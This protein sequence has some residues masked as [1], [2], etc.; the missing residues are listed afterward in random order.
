MV[1]DGRE[2]IAA[3]DGDGLAGEPVDGTLDAGDREEAE[4]STAMV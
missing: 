4:E 2:A 1:E 3:H